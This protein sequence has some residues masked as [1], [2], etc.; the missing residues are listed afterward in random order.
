M[1]NLTVLGKKTIEILPPNGLSEV[2]ILLTGPYEN[3]RPL[4]RAS[5]AVLSM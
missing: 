3:W 1:Q 5:P 4:V 2:V